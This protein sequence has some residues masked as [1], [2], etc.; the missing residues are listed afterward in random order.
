MKFNISFFVLA[1]LLMLLS[2]SD[3]YAQTNDQRNR[4]SVSGEGIVKVEPDMVSVRFGVVTRDEDPVKARQLNEE[5]SAKALE[6]V[7]NLGV[8]ERKMKVTVLQLNEIREY[9]R[10]RRRQISAGFEAIRQVV[11]ELDEL[12]KLPQLIA[13]VTQHGANRLFGISYDISNR[14][15]IRN[16]ALKKAA[17]DAREKATVLSSEL[18]VTLGKVLTVNEQSFHF[19]GPIPVRAMMAD[20]REAAMDMGTPEAYAAGEIEVRAQVQIEFL[21]E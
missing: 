17:A 1:G 4:I 7:R 2:A 18:N 16:E 20:Q 10:E 12:D 13:Q 21:I 19:P 8:P 14:D 11:V 6:A 3:G 5:A 9:D 15:V